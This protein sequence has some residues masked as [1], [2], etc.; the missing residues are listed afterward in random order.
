MILPFLAV[1]GALRPISP[2]GEA[3]VLSKQ[4]QVVKVEIL[5]PKQIH[6]RQQ[7]NYWHGVIVPMILAC[8]LNE[9]EWAVQPTHESVH[10][11]LVRAVFGEVDTPLGPERKSSTNLTIEQYSEL[12]ENGKNYLWARYGV[13]APEPNE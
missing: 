13:T 12:I 3:V 5:T 7:E 1:K 10:G 11:R 6:S 8:W 2:E 4:G 9:K